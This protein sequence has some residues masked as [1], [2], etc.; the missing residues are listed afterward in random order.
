MTGQCV[1]YIEMRREMFMLQDIKDNGL[2]IPEPDE[3]FTDQ[4][5][6]SEFE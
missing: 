5:E 6:T 2:D 3:D 1:R 4:D